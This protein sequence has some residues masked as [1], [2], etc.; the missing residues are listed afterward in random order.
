MQRVATGVGDPFVCSS[1]KHDRLAPLLPATLA[2]RH[3][4][5]QAL[6]LQAFPFELA[7]VGQEPPVTGGGQHVHAA[8]DTG[9]A[10]PIDRTLHW[11][12]F[13]LKAAVP[14]AVLFNDPRPLKRRNHSP[15][16]HLYATNA[17]DVHALLFSIEF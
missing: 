8:I 13:A 12:P 14:P 3:R 1:Q 15:R 4:T 16:T 5:L 10:T 2:P 9:N 17:G 6:D 7:R 11:Q